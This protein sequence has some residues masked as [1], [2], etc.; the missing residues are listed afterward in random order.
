MSIIN[1]FYIW[2]LK[3]RGRNFGHIDKAGRQVG[4]FI[5]IAIGESS[6]KPSTFHQHYLESLL[7]TSNI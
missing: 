6:Q 4:A 5:N 2:L 7:L 3:G 1:I